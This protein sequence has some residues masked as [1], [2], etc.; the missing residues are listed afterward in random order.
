MKAGHTR[1]HLLDQAHNGRVCIPPGEGGHA[2][3]HDADHLKLLGHDLEVTHMKWWEA[4]MRI[5]R[6]GK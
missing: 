1:A 6:E 5:E 3:G 4:W 2:A